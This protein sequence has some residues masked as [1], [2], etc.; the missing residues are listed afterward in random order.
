[1]VGAFPCGRVSGERV[2][3]GSDA[4]RGQILPP[5]SILPAAGVDSGVWKSNP[6][7]PYAARLPS[8]ASP[9]YLDGY[10]VCLRYTYKH[11][12][13]RAIR[14]M[15][16]YPGIAYRL[17]SHCLHL[18]LLQRLSVFNFCMRAISPSS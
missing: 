11:R 15:N 8:G 6:R 17:N 4:L 14:Q 2:D 12:Q 16:R 9:P 1:M 18:A 10:A 3:V 13:N 7:F 5:Y